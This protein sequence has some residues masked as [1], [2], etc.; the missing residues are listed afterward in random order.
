LIYE[1]AKAVDEILDGTCLPAGRLCRYQ[2]DIDQ[3]PVNRHYG[4]QFFGFMQ[5]L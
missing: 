1:T 3:L 5:K 2:K 4:Y